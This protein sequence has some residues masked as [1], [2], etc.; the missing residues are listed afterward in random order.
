MT[1][2]W[3]ELN[4]KK[5]LNGIISSREIEVA[6]QKKKKS[7]RKHLTLPVTVS[8]VATSSPGAQPA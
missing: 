5:V 1:S 4:F 3:I 7:T 2:N 6:L 8:T